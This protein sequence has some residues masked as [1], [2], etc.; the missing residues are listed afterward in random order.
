M[1]EVVPEDEDEE[2]SAG[3]WITCQFSLVGDAIAAETGNGGLTVRVGGVCLAI[4]TVLPV[5]LAFARTTRLGG[6]GC[7]LFANFAFEIPAGWAKWCT[8][9]LIGPGSG[10]RE[11]EF[12]LVI[13]D[14]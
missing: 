6:T 10:S 14:S 4:T 9:K 11:V 8:E 5:A 13:S 3:H 2:L 1:V 7:R 12:A